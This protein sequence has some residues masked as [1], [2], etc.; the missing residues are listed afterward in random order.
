MDQESHAYKY[1]SYYKI[2]NIDIAKCFD[3]LSHN[4]ILKTV[5]LTFKYSY[6]LK[7]WLNSSLIGPSK[8]DGRIVKETSMRGV[9]Q[10]SIIGV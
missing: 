3:E 2:I 6:L 1:T 4:D 9:P 7:S 8:K 5:P 10:G